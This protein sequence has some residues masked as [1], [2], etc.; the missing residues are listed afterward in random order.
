[1]KAITKGKIDLYKAAAKKAL[2]D[3]EEEKLVD[4]NQLMKAIEQKVQ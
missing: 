3:E 2:Q 1:M 4:S